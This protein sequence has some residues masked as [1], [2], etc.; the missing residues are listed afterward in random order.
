MLQKRYRKYLILFL[1]TLTATTMLLI[2]GQLIASEIRIAVASNFATAIKIISTHFEARTGHK[3]TLIFGSTG[4][5]YAQIK[6]GAPFDI[7]LAA[8]GLRP[9]LLEKEN[10]ALPESR[11]TYAIG[12]LVLWSPQQGYVDTKG[13][14]LTF[15]EFRHLAIANPKLAPYG[16]AAQEILTSRGLWDQ[17]SERL[18]RGENISQTFQF[19]KSGNAKLGFIAYSQV[20]RINQAIDGSFWVVPQA[21]YAAIEQQAILLKESVTARAFLLFLRSEV[22]LQIIHDEGYD[23]P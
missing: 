3:V 8:D 15:G 20:K 9:A 5:H 7:F 6:N 17:I 16:K 21:L 1:K 11:F 23:T 13:H 14:V 19:V 4:K 18:V 12:K 22:A 10:L 2:T